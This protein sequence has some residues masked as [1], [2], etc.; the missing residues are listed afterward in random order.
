MPLHQT[1]PYHR[2]QEHSLAVGQ[3]VVD[4]LV[5]IHFIRQG[6]VSQDD[7]GLGQSGPQTGQHGKRQFLQLLLGVLLL[8]QTHLPP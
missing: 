4:K 7:T 6:V 3:K 5:G 8:P 2:W 1:L